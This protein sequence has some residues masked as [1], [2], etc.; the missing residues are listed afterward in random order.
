MKITIKITFAL[1]LFLL[2]FLGYI[3]N[4]FLFYLFICIHELSHIL[5]SKLF[6]LSTYKINFLFLGLNATIK[7]FNFVTPYK[8]ILILLAGPFSNLFFALIFYFLNY[9]TIYI[10]N[11]CLFIFNLLPIFPLDGGQILFTLLEKNGYIPIKIII[12]I[13][14]ICLS[15]FIF[16]VGIIQIIL[17]PYNFSLLLIGLYLFKY[18]I[19]Y[20]KEKI[21]LSDFYY[22]LLCKRNSDKIKFIYSN[23]N[24]K[25]KDM[26]KY[27]SINRTLIFVYT[28]NKQHILVDENKI[29]HE[30]LNQ[31][32]NISL[33]ELTKI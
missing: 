30:I 20:L 12:T 26:L 25:I 3:D 4:Y 18:N 23:E 7:N 8:K 14:S 17:F 6:K 31:N 21:Y 13:L 16:I 10:S 11:L 28:K 1:F 15:M 19:K 27:F 24:T 2:I 32:F 9:K 33:I 5:V 29:A 22:I